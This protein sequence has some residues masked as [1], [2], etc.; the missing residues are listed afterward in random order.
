MLKV[1][2]HE[3]SQI[4]LK[5]RDKEDFLYFIYI[6]MFLEVRILIGGVYSVHAGIIPVK[7]NNVK[8]LV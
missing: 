1:R 4:M 3:I 6:W 7:K 5:V 8:A 2:D